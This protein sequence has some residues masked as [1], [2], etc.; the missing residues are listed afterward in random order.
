MKSNKSPKTPD[1]KRHSNFPTTAPLAPFQMHLM[2]TIS[3]DDTDWTYA[4]QW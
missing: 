3:K 4:V 1:G 2:K